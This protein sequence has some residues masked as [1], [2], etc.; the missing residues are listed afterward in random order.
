[1]KKMMDEWNL[2]DVENIPIFFS[3]DNARNISLATSQLSDI[4]LYCFAHT[5]QLVL[6]DAESRTPCVGELLTKVSLSFN[7]KLSF[8]VQLKSEGDMRNF[9]SIYL[10]ILKT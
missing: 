10:R 1:M 3:T 2:S 4:Y 9:F 5:L 6:K 7:C 8:I